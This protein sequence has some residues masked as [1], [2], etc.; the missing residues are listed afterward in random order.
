MAMPV[1]NEAQI[2][3]KPGEYITNGMPSAATQPMVN[4]ILAWRG[5]ASLNFK[6]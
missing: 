4:E 5:A 3:P 2:K 6:K 1:T